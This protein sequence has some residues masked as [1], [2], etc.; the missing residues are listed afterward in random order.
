[1]GSDYWPRH[2]QNKAAERLKIG[3]CHYLAMSVARKLRARCNQNGKFLSLITPD[4][5][6]IPKINTDRHEKY[7]QALSV[8]G[9]E[10]K[11][12]A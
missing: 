11:A 9:E 12:G 7:E 2:A 1:M 10:I 6:L 8:H 4:H 5:A 3:I